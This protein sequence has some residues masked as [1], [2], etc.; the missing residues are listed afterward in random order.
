MKSLLATGLRLAGLHSQRR[1]L[2]GPHSLSPCNHQLHSVTVPACLR[3]APCDR[4]HRILADPFG[5]WPGQAYPNLGCEGPAKHSPTWVP[6]SNPFLVRAGLFSGVHKNSPRLA[7]IAPGAA[8][9]LFLVE[10]GVSHIHERP[11][12][13]PSGRFSQTPNER[14]A[15][16]S[17]ERGTRHHSPGSPAFSH[18]HHPLPKA[19]RTTFWTTKGK[20]RVAHPFEFYRVQRMLHPRSPFFGDMVGIPTSTL[21]HA[22]AHY[23]AA[24]KLQ[25]RVSLS[26]SLS[27]SQPRSDPRTVRK[28]LRKMASLPPVTRAYSDSN[29]SSMRCAILQKTRP[30]LGDIFF[31][32]RS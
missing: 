30:T 32:K 27:L 20:W 16:A 5:G 3:F 19:A 25:R 29:S 24:P 11:S 4:H 22:T 1:S 8:F 17:L 14:S 13:V 28:L 18:P 23:R 15:Q 7:K 21:T 26:L 12:P 6:R 2:E 9:S 10:W 31:C